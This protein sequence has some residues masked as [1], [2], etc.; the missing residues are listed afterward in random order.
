MAVRQTVSLAD[1]EKVIAEAGKY[2]HA[3]KVARQRTAEVKA[4]NGILA[5]ELA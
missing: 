1:Y 2:R 4:S 5:K 3:A